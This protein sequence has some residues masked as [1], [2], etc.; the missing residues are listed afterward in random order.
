M[1]HSVNEFTNARCAGPQLEFRY[2]MV[3]SGVD[4]IISRVMASSNVMD[5]VMSLLSRSCASANFNVRTI[6]GTSTALKMPPEI[7]VNST[8]GIMAPV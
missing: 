2:S 4:A 1:H 8:C 7:T 5:T 6:C 3:S